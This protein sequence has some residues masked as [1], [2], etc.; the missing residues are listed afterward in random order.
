[1]KYRQ[2]ICLLILVLSLPSG[3]TS[4]KIVAASKSDTQLDIT[5]NIDQVEVD[6]L[7]NVYILTSDDKII[8]YDSEL[9]KKYEYNNGLIG[10]II[11]IDA[12]NPQ[13]IL[14]FIADFNRILVLDNTLAEIKT[15]DLSST[16]FLDITA[17]AR[18]NDNRI[19]IFDPINQVLVKIDNLGKAQ[20]TSNRLSDYNL[21]NVNPIIIREKENK[22]S[23]VDE[24]LGILIFDNFGQFL[25]LIPETDVKYIQIFGDYIFY[26][27]RGAFFQYHID[28]HDKKQINLNGEGFTKFKM[29][30]E[31]VYL[32]GERGL[33]RRSNN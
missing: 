28:R 13:K 23:V 33:I 21:G 4:Q 20:F 2:L 11:S 8:R 6:N 25:K 29:T 5:E 15:L 22:V 27:Q 9:N 17:V 19:W 30:K 16:E 18:S 3:I 12:T 14:C 7:Q 24:Q 32:F 26:A 1:M 10:D 31:Y